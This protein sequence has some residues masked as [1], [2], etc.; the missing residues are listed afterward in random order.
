MMYS[1]HHHSEKGNRL[2]Q[3]LADEGVL[4][5]DQLMEG[6]VEDEASFFEHEEGGGGVG[7]AF[8]EGNHAALLGVEAVVAEEEGVLDAV[9]D[10]DRRS[11][12]DVAFLDDQ[13]DDGGGGKGVEAAR[14]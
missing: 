5:F 7:Y 12:V 2:L 11:V 1:I 4:A 13:L 9:G 8:G 10:H 6:A 3:E 14:G